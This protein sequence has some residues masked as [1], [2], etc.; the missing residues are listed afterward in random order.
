MPGRGAGGMAPEVAEA[1][2]DVLVAHAG[3]SERNREEFVHHQSSQFRSGY[4]FV[5]SLGQGGKFWRNYGP[6]PDGTYGEVWYVN[7]YA[8]DMTEVRI[9]AI[10]TTD[11][12][13]DALRSRHEQALTA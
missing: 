8:E 13:L 3:A 5:G 9:H 6:R 4:R 1:V 12:L 11:V 7:A 2:Y 10:R